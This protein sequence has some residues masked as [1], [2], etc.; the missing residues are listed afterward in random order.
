M[1]IW[2]FAQE[3]NGAPTSATLELVTKARSLGTVTAFKSKECRPQEDKTNSHLD[4]V[5]ISF[6]LQ[7]SGQFICSARYGT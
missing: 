6:F 1:N 4:C 3:A 2:V 5:I 7:R